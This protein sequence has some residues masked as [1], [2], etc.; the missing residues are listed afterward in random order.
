MMMMLR[1]GVECLQKI[2]MATLRGRAEAIGLLP[3]LDPVR[4]IFL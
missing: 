2:A 4:R 1:K 3:Y